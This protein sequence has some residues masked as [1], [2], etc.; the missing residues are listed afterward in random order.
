MSM[1]VCVYVCMCML[2]FSNQS[3]FPIHAQCSWNMFWIHHNP[4]HINNELTEDESMNTLI[5]YHSKDI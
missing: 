2:Q 3:V 4:D 5:T 1:S